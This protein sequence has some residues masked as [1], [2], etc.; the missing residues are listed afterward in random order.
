MTTRRAVVLSE[1]ARRCPI[2]WDDLQK[3]SRTACGHAFCEE[4]I[5]RA[6]RLKKECPS[7]R[8]P[9]NH[10]MLVRIEGSEDVVPVIPRWGHS[11]P[12]LSRWGRPTAPAQGGEEAERPTKRTRGGRPEQTEEHS[13][14]EMDASTSTDAPR[15]RPSGATLRGKAP[16]ARG[17][18]ARALIP[19]L[20][21]TEEAQSPAESSSSRKVASRPHHGASTGFWKAGEGWVYPSSPEPSSEVPKRF[22]KAGDGWVYPDREEAPQ[23]AQPAQRL[24]PAMLVRRG[25]RRRAGRGDAAAVEAGPEVAYNPCASA[26]PSDGLRQRTRPAALA[27]QRL[28]RQEHAGWVETKAQEAVE[29]KVTEGE[30]TEGEVTEGEVTE[31]DL[32]EGATEGAT[33]GETE[34]E[35]EGEEGGW[36]CGILGCRKPAR[37]AGLCEVACGETRQRR[38]PAWRQAEAEGGRAPHKRST[39]S[40]YERPQGHEWP[41]QDTRSRPS[42]ART[43]AR[44]LPTQEATASRDSPDGGPASIHASYLPGTLVY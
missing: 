28:E 7:C 2:C 24:P 19:E 1:I 39:G 18:K 23:W 21:A 15:Q 26:G 10:R 36:I 30:V 43:P 12:E 38:L 27:R 20:G 8:T 33:E 40:D 6:L 14:G 22:C 4:C 9:M 31:G 3:P 37:H 35:E 5:L 29:G 17:A 41:R 32:T 42:R 16:A 34:G 25:G 13:D 44:G 11:A